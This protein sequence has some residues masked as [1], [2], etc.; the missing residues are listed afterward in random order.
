MKRLLDEWPKDEQSAAR[1]KPEYRHA[2]MRGVHV[3]H[4]IRWVEG[5]NA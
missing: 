3:G 2:L 5:G 4:F 1:R